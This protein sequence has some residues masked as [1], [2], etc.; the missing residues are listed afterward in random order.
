MTS[1]ETLLALIA[2][3]NQSILDSFGVALTSDKISF[4]YPVAGDYPEGN[5]TMIVASVKNHRK[6]RD[7]SY[8]YYYGRNDLQAAF[9][10]IGVNEVS[11]KLLPDE[12][13]INTVL[14]ALK[15][16]YNFQ[17][18]AIEVISDSYVGDKYSFTVT[19]NSLLWKNSL[20]VTI[21]DASILLAEAFP[22]NI[23][24]GFVLPVFPS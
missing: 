17:L 14:N 2:S 8:T 11:V 9:T 1:K 3:K 6:V 4:G 24:D 22:N 21:V 13:N 15:L 23:L 12:V 18:D 7:S 16:K 5:D 20:T 10:A 19:Q